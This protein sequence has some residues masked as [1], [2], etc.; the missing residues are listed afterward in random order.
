[1]GGYATTR[2]KMATEVVVV[3]AT[4]IDAADLEAQHP[5]ISTPAPRALR[6]AARAFRCLRGADVVWLA[7]R[8]SRAQN[9]VIRCS[10]GVRSTAGLGLRI[11]PG[12]DGIGGAV[13]Q[14]G[15]SW[16][17][18]LTDGGASALSTQET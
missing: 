18:E 6:L 15:E 11:E 9:A 1:M 14:S 13:L 2:A 16:R 10:Q 12:G 3:T 5:R 17:G 4:I 7:V 8:E